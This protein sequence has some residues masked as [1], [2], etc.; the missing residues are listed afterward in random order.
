MTQTRFIEELKRRWLSQG[1]GSDPVGC[2]PPLPGPCSGRR[3][4]SLF[5]PAVTNSSKLCPWRPTSVLERKRTKKGPESRTERAGKLSHLQTQ[6]RSEP[7]PSPFGRDRASLERWHRTLLGKGSASS[8]FSRK[9]SGNALLWEEEM[10]R[11]GPNTEPG[12]RRK[13]GV[14]GLKA[15]KT[16]TNNYPS[17]LSRRQ[18]RWDPL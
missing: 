5:S 4:T 15:S 7:G 11:N 1:P 17:Y 10:E 14:S 2:K 18:V 13:T 6:A 12:R 16:K 8:S 3:F 9:E